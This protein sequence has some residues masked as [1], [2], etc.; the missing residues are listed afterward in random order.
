MGMSP[1]KPPNSKTPFSHQTLI[2]PPHH[3]IKEKRREMIFRHHL[4]SH[5]TQAPTPTNVL[6]ML[7]LFGANFGGHQE[8]VNTHPL[9]N[10][11]LCSLWDPHS[12]WCAFFNHCFLH[13]GRLV[14]SG[15]FGQPKGGG[16]L[17]GR[18]Q[19]TINKNF[20]LFFF[21]PSRGQ[22]KS[23]PPRKTKRGGSHIEGEA[24]RPSEFK[25]CLP[26]FEGE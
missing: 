18:S 16:P 2:L 10:T 17:K 14:G 15:F 26:A 5:I 24:R 11:I 9:A 6:G 13:P 21:S 3:A 7:E 23:T 4:K 8:K 25:P 20:S 12:F 22:V 19:V 1:P